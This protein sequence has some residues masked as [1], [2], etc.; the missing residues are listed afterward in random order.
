MHAW[1][2]TKVM[3]EN[4][5]D[6]ETTDCPSFRSVF[7]TFYPCALVVRQLIADNLRNRTGKQNTAMAVAVA[8]L[9]EVQFRNRVK[10]FG[11][12]WPANN[13]IVRA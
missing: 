6:S 8:P 2:I 9:V 7:V 12:A 1:F 13:G 3:L 4:F 5:V 11:L 10:Q